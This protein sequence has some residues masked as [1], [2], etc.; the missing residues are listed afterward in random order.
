MTK[1]RFQENLCLFV[2]STTSGERCIPQGALNQSPATF[3]TVQLTRGKSKTLQNL[4]KSCS[5]YMSPL[6]RRDSL[7]YLTLTLLPKVYF[8]A[9]RKY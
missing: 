3:E 5:T 8:I 1:L 4:G 2:T 6:Q 9:L 7:S